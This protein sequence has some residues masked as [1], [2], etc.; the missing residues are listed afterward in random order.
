MVPQ[1][2][3]D[4]VDSILRAL[5]GEELRNDGLYM[6]YWSYIKIKKIQKF[7]EKIGPG[8][9]NETMFSIFYEKKIRKSGNRG[10]KP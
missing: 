2:D 5:E 9:P 3:F 6:K 4:I 1:V 10:R 7:K 8:S